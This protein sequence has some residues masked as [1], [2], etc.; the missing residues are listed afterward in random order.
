MTY[1]NIRPIRVQERNDLGRFLKIG[2]VLEL[3]IYLEEKVDKWW[4]H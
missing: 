3:Y 2:I 1:K 4:R